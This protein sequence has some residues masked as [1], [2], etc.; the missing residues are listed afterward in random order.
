MLLLVLALLSFTSSA[1]DWQMVNVTLNH[2]QNTYCDPAT[3]Q[4]RAYKGTLAGHTI[5]DSIKDTHG[6]IGYHQGQKAIY[7]SFRG[8]DS[9]QNWIS[10]INAI[11]TTYPAPGCSNCEVHKGFYQAEQSCFPDVLNHVKTLKSTYPDYQVVVTGHSLGAALATLVSVDLINVGI[12]PV[13]M[14]NYGSPRVGDTNF[15]NY[16]NSVIK[17]R[18]RI[19]HHKDLVPHSPMHE[20]FTHHS[21]E[22]YEPSDDVVLNAC[23]GNEDSNCSYQWHITSVSDHLYY[24]GLSMGEGDK[25]CAAFL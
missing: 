18:N 20:R 16:V 1:L 12:S 24:L 5:N 4:S 23:S 21:G 11:L 13:R 8:S 17:D 3:Y 25:E 6:Y 15:A 22:W 7:V 2:A 19:T 9:I 14:F 10:N